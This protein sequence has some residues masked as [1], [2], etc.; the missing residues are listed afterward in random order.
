MTKNAQ[1]K[2]ITTSKNRFFEGEVVSDKMNKTIT[3]KVYRTLKHP[4]TGK[5]IKKFK[6]YKSHDEA[7]IAHIGD[8]VKIAECRP[9]S[10]F[11][12]TKLVQILRKVV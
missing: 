2:Q 5:T 1:T 10:K 3:V 8:W 12:H 4:I 9:L 11:K 7:N 6:K